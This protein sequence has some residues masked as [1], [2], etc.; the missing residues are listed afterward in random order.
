MVVVKRGNTLSAAAAEGSIAM[1][2]QAVSFQAGSFCCVATK[3]A[4]L[5]LLGCQ[6]LLSCMLHALPEA[7][8][9]VRRCPALG[10]LSV[11]PQHQ[12]RAFSW[13]DKPWAAQPGRLER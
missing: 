8:E 2:S 13:L 3:L 1:I 11:A 9:F 10:T 7:G 5:H 6:Q 4:N 12:Y